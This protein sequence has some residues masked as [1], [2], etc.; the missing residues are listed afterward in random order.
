MERCKQKLILR[1]QCNVK[2]TYSIVKVI[3][4]KELYNFFRILQ[5]DILFLAIIIKY[6]IIFITLIFKFI[7][8]F[9]KNLNVQLKL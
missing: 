7:I 3:L 2:N 9:L 5:Q 6:S 4:K 8:Y 1:A